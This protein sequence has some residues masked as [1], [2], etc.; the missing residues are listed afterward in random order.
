M[1]GRPKGPF[2]RAIIERAERFA[3]LCLLVNCDDVV[4]LT[5]AVAVVFV[6]DTHCVMC[7]DRVPKCVVPK[8][9]LSPDV[10]NWLSAMC[11][12]DKSY[13]LPTTTF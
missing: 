2:E 13:L 6:P 11:V 8:L 7:W 4:P 9:C 12:C 10:E 1:I 5:T 3:D